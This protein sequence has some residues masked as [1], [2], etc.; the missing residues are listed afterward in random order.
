MSTVTCT[1]QTLTDTQIRVGSSISR[2]VTG[3]GSV[4]ARQF[5]GEHQAEAMVSESDLQ[6]S[7]FIS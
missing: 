2:R 1:H 7:P 3:G 6:P 5:T 4:A